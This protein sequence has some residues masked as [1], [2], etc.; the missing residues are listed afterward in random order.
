MMKCLTGQA[1]EARQRAWMVRA[2][3]EQTNSYF[4]KKTHGRKVLW[5]WEGKEPTEIIRDKE[6]NS[7]GTRSEWKEGLDAIE[8]EM[9]SFV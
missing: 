3:V 2:R 7:L 6:A 9:G 1:N 8:T 4:R 5:G